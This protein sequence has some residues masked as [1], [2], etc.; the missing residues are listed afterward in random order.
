[1]NLER[2]RQIF[3]N[4]GRCSFYYMDCSLTCGPVLAN[5]CKKLDIVEVHNGEKRKEF[6][7]DKLLA[8]GYD[9]RIF[10]VLL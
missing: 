9:E 4:N 5:F 6:V 2:Y 10:E 7:L 1:M 8:N 3:K